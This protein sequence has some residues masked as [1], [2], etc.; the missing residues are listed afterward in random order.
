MTPP[1][2]PSADGDERAKFEAVEGLSD[3]QIFATSRATPQIES[4]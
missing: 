3:E 4:R 2:T 1:I